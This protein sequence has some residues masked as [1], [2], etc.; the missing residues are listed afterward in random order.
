M[1]FVVVSFPEKAFQK[2]INPLKHLFISQEGS[3]SFG[4]FARCLD[5]NVTWNIDSHF[6]HYSDPEYVT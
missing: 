6:I 4:V 5:K 1:H 2:D 3:A